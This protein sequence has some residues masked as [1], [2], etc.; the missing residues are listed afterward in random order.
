MT[1]SQYETVNKT[2]TQQ[3]SD[4]FEYDIDKAIEEQKQNFPNPDKLSYEDWK[5]LNEEQQK[6]HYDNWTAQ[7]LVETAQERGEKIHK[8]VEESDTYEKFLI[9]KYNL[10]PQKVIYTPQ[11]TEQ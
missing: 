8:E 9:K 7:P 4:Y 1:N 10:D 5:E 2:V 6:L 3:M 11:T